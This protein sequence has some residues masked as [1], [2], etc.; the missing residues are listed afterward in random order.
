MLHYVAKKNLKT[1]H[2]Q[3]KL[4]SRENDNNSWQI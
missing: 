2:M 1:I 4:T 3:T